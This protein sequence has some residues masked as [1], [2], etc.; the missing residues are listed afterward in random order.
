MH[1]IQTH[2]QLSNHKEKLETKVKKTL[3]TLHYEVR[4]VQDSLHAI[5]LKKIYREQSQGTKSA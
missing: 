5:N 2:K 3:H 1:Q 4:E